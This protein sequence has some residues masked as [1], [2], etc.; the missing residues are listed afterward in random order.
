M[1]SKRFGKVDFEPYI[2]YNSAPE[3]RIEFPADASSKLG[4]VGFDVDYACGGF[5][6]SFEFAQNF[7]HQTVHG[8]DRN[9]IISQ[10]N[11]TTAAVTHVNSKVFDTASGSSVSALDTKANQAAI[12]TSIEDENQNGIGIP[13]TTLVNASDRF[14]NP[15]F[16]EYKGWM[17]VFDAG[18]WFLQKQIQIAVAAGIAT[19]D[20]N[21]NSNFDDPKAAPVCS[22]PTN[23]GKHNFHGFVGLQEIYN[24]ERVESAY[25]L[26]QRKITRP[27]SL[28]ND[29]IDNGFHADT[30]SEFTNIIY[31]GTGF[32]I[33]PK[34]TNK[35]Y[36]RP[37]ILFYWQQKPTRAFD[38]ATQ[39]VSPT[40]FARDFLGTEF[41][42]FV[43][44]FPLDSLKTTFVFSWFVPGSHYSDVRGE[45]VNRT[46]LQLLQNLDKENFLADALSL[47][48][49][50]TDPSFSFNLAFEYRF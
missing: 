6:A 33:K 5:E 37:N 45:P 22:T 38:L 42:T 3:Q 43:D 31:C 13:G 18:Y 30:V 35:F 10:L 40:R 49:L 28:P 25:V 17:I 11:P 39:T 41:N 9:T 27:L 15:Y 48:L 19:G 2:L 14:S 46:Q 21:P 50:G 26:G 4:T 34:W 36:W 47:P 24:G 1:D 12:N 20:E 23:P 8:W 16:N 29:A 7:G 44:I 32:H